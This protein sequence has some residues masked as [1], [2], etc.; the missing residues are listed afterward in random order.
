MRFRISAR[1]L[2]ASFEREGA[3]GGYR[4]PSSRV[5]QPHGV[6]DQLLVLDIAELDASGERSGPPC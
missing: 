5:P 4:L 1:I 2:R 3:Q 6:V